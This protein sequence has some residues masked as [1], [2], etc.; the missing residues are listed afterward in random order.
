MGAQKS[1]E[2]KRNYFKLLYGKYADAYVEMGVKDDRMSFVRMYNMV[3]KSIDSMEFVE[4]SFAWSALYK[5]IETEERLM[6][7]IMERFP[8][9]YDSNMSIWLAKYYNEITEQ[10][11][12]KKIYFFKFK[13]LLAEDVYQVIL[14]RA[15]E[16]SL[17]NEHLKGIEE[18]IR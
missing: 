5:A 13:P 8:L 4:N 9:E 2:A 18:Y 1:A 11:I 7:R 3:M 15:K 10:D 14:D 17:D 6:I 12:T 16:L